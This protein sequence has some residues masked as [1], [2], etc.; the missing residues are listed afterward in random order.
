M[1]VSVIVFP[2][3]APVLVGVPVMALIP[4]RSLGGT[5]AV[6]VAMM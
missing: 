5:M 1:I 4:V 6:V 2:V 3:L